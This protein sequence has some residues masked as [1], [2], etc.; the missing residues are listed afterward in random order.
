[1]LNYELHVQ[2]ALLYAHCSQTWLVLRFMQYGWEGVDFS[3]GI[4]LTKKTVGDAEWDWDSESFI[5]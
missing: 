1:M 4:A 3:N 2:N 5:P